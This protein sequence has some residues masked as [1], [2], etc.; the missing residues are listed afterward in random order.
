MLN[1]HH[2]NNQLLVIGRPWWWCV[3][4]GWKLGSSQ[5]YYYCPT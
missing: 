1:T 5:T 4:K 3:L 2:L